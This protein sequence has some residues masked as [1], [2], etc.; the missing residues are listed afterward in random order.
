MPDT[1]RRSSVD[2]PKRTT[3]PPKLS[4][5]ERY[6]RGR[7]I[8]EM[9]ARAKPIAWREIAKQVGMS[10]SGAKEAHAQFLE[11]EEP[12]HDPSTF[13]QET[14]D[15][16][17]VAMHEA[18]RNA[19]MAEEGSSARVQSLRAAMDAVMTRLQVAR[20]AGRAPR[21]LSAPQVATQMQLVFREFATLLE[22]HKVGDEVL[23]D[24]LALAE[25]QIGRLN[26]VDGRELPSAA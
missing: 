3:R 9:R 23:R 16:L 15:A 14:L 17:T 4:P 6:A 26:A 11:W 13:V 21:S 10:E 24:F 18:F 20:A 1:G 22:R 2:K 8:A 7:R 12:L 25:S 5:L 19:A